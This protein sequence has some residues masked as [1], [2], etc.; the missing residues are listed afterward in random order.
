MFADATPISE[1]IG[2]EI[3]GVAGHTLTDPKAAARCQELVDEYGVVV[4]REAKITDGDLVE[5]SRMLGEVVVPPM[6]GQED[7][8]EVSA[9]SLDPAKTVLASY[10]TGTFYWHIDGAT[11]EVPQKGTLLTALQV[12][13]EG[14]DT[15]FANTYASY[16]AL[17]DRDKAEF[18]TLRVVH[19][20]AAAQRLAN[21]EPTEKQEA[22]W[23]RVP[24]REHPLVW[25]RRSGRKSLLIGATASHVVGWPEEQSKALI[26]RLL[27]WSTQPRFSL[28][29]HWQPGDLVLW[30]NTGMLHRAVPYSATSPRLLHRTT[31][32]G[33]EAVA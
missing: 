13:D 20:F 7:H 14:G 1:G 6:G 8:P 11:D 12:S 31:L 9:I 22:A 23:A 30:D 29:H 2:A 24:E 10:N 18:E 26:S 21:P 3:T 32:V 4:F 5:L 28:R 25:T 19:S 15:E 17:S 16:E 27:A 33:E